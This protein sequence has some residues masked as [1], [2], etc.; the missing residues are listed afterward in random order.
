MVPWL[1]LLLAWPLVSVALRLGCGS[2]PGLSHGKGQLPAG[3]VSSSCQRW[4]VISPPPFSERRQQS[5]EWF[6]G[7]CLTQAGWCWGMDQ[8]H[9]ARHPLSQRFVQRGPL[10]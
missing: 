3:Q 5:P 7:R 10:G 8:E 1:R 2:P 4:G 6:P 9:F